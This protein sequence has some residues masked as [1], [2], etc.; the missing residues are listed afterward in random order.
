MEANIA[1]ATLN[2]LFAGSA[3]AA[4]S[5]T[6]SPAAFLVAITMDAGNPL[7]EL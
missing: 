3:G 1:I 7:G 5:A 6:N 2:V 4:N